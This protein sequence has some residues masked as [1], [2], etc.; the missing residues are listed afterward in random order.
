MVTDWSQTRRGHDNDD[1][2]QDPSSNVM[3]PQYYMYQDPFAHRPPLQSCGIKGVLSYIPYHPLMPLLPVDNLPVYHA[4]PMPNTRSR[5][6]KSLYKNA[7]PPS[8]T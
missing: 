4:T 5:V 7:F 8:Y 6:S 2:P 3:M 1:Q